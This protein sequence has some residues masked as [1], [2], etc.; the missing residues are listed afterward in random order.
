MLEAER[1]LKKT[2]TAD[3]KVLKETLTAMQSQ[4]SEKNR[5]ELVL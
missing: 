1:K 5:L 3:N 2:L 4:K